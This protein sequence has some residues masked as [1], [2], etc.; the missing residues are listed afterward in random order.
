M[1]EKGNNI[2]LRPHHGMCLAYFEGRGYSRGFSVHMGK[3]LELLE[4]DAYVVSAEQT[5]NT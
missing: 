5:E 3:I 4:K 2:C 1:K